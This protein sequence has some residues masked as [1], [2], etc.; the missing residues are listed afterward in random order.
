MPFDGINDPGLP[1]NVVE[2]SAGKRRQWVGAFNGSFADCDSDDCE[3]QAFRIANA[4]VKEMSVMVEE[5]RS[6]EEG[7]KNVDFWMMMD[8]QVTQ[9][10]AN[11]SVDGGLN[12]K[13]CAR[14]RWF[15]SPNGCLIVENWPLSIGEIGTSDR[16]EEATVQD[17]EP[18]PV[19]VV[20]VEEGTSQK[21]APPPTPD[22]STDTGSRPLKAAYRAGSGSIKLFGN[23]PEHAKV[24]KAIKQ[25]GE[26]AK[27]L[28]GKSADSPDV[29][30]PDERNGMKVF[31]DSDGK[32]RV[33]AWASNNRRD[34]DTPSELFEAKAHK[35]FV[36]Y[37]D[38]GG[39]YPEMWLWHTPGTKWGQ[40]D[41]AD[42]SDGFLMY[43]GTVDPGME[44]VAHSL[45]SEKNLGVSHGYRYRYSDKERGI[46]GW[47]RDY[48]LSPLLMDKAANAWT[49][50]DILVKEAEEMGFTKAKRDFL[51][52]HLGEGKVASLENDTATM[53]KELN[54]L[55]VEWKDVPDADVDAKADEGAKADAT[56]AAI[57]YDLIGKKAAE[58]V[59]ASDGFKGLTDG[60]K[61]VTDR[62]DVLEADMKG[63]KASDEEKVASNFAPRTEK[64]LA[65]H[66]ASEDESNVKAEGDKA[67]EFVESRS[68]MHSGFMTSIIGP[69]QKREP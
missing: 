5:T 27:A 46:I 23:D 50:I 3:G 60:M 12:G 8:R 56:P 54:A 22:P 48:E 10:E 64:V 49:G 29:P 42:Y 19:P 7:K 52:G 57:D 68:P 13:P 15:V 67:D 16:F 41:W 36:D 47:Y 53:V 66:R 30:D 65:G 11:Y 35:E 62:L 43:S 34:H 55:G 69:P 2:M 40:T 26:K 39:D 28:M 31:T 14:C 20:I 37:L 25:I 38:Q 51:V 21:S 6:K 59:I 44:S 32:L 1:K 18:D 9:E 45:A 58:G 63:V 17:F 4:A 61:S 24:I 33:F